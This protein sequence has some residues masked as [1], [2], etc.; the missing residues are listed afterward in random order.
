ML[1]RF[2][3]E[4]FLSFKESAE[5]SMMASKIVKH[6]DHVASCG[7]RRILK[8]S[9]IFGP[10][11]SGKSNFM[12]AVDFA[13]KIILEGPE[14]VNLDKMHFR[15]DPSCREKPGVFQFDI[16][17]QGHFY[18]YGFALSYLDA[19]FK[20]E[21]LY[22]IDGGKD[23]CIFLRS[24]DED[25]EGYAIT[26]DMKFADEKAR[27]TF[28]FYQEAFSMKKMER[29]LF[30]RDVFEHISEDSIDYQPYR[31]V[32]NWF[33]QLIVIFPTSVF[34]GL[35]SLFASD[36]DK[37]LIVH[38]LRYFDTGITSID[39]KEVDLGKA[40]PYPE[41]ETLKVDISNSLREDGQSVFLRTP[42][43][44]ME[45]KRDGGSLHAYKVLTRHGE[46]GDLFEFG[47]ESDGTQRL[48]D[49]IPV[50]KNAFSGSVILIDEIDRSLHT[51]AVKAFI[52]YFFSST[53]GVNSQLIMTTH[54]SNVLNLSF[55]RQDE[56]WFIDRRK[57]YS[58]RLYSLNKFNVRFDKKIENDYLIGRFG[59][60][61]EFR[62]E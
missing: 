44:L 35:G 19:S 38:L 8:S 16:F 7:G 3:V 14:R 61:P 41:D 55:L 37:D 12:K 54:D 48:F 34:R 33:E 4:N 60:V 47:N 62:Q 27:K 6:G 30:L 59:A 42:F 51:N 29:K 50:F 49:L 20:E 36:S 18:S 46:G 52:D 2:A 28:D 45:V 40:F 9:C 5:F 10:N 26:T 13:R 39:R 23:F 25:G 43:S 57:D 11:A 31:D 56:I 58:S 53:Y 22:R 17:S 1:I 15:I 32:I 24:E 21:W